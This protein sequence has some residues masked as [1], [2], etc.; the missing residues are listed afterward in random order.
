MTGPELAEHFGLNIQTINKY[1]RKGL[2]PR[3]TGYGRWS[4]YD[5]ICVRLIE[6]YQYIREHF[7]ATLD[8]LAERRQLTGQ[9]LPPEGRKPPVIARGAV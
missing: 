5:P 2:I 9:L 8:D 1:A 6:Q 3:P 4:R 7:G